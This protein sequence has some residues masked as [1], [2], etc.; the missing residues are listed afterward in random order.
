MDLIVSSDLPATCFMAL[1]WAADPNLET[2]I[3]ILIAGRIPSSVASDP[4][5][6]KLFFFLMEE[7]S[8]FQRFYMNFI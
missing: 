5:D 3:P 2:E 8:V 6:S 7:K 1:I 4:K